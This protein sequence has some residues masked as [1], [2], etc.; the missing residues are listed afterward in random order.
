MAD[1]DQF[2]FMLR[3]L[4]LFAFEN[5]DE[6]WW[7]CDAEYAPIT[8]FVNCNDCYAWGS[9]DAEPITPADLP[10]LEQTFK[11]VIALGYTDGE[12]APLLFVSRKRRLRP[13]GAMYKYITDDLV[14]LHDECGP[15][16]PPQMGNPVDHRAPSD[17]VEV[18]TTEGQNDGSS[19]GQGA[20]AVG[21]HA[22]EGRPHDQDGG[23]S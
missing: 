11:D 18:T 3:V 6:L 22:E 19:V 21:G 23:D 8:F 7:R 13:Q 5:T 20:A 17:E 9:A 4:E 10:L 15:Y 1:N 2:E 14:P 16:R 12:G